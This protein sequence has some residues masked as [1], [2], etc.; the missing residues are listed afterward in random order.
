MYYIIDFITNLRTIRY[1]LNNNNCGQHFET[2]HVIVALL[3]LLLLHFIC[4][5]LSNEIWT[6]LPIASEFL[7][8]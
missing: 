4:I 8:S 1:V 6:S 7:L 5:S 2:L 3:Q